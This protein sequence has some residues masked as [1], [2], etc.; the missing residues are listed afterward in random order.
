[1]LPLPLTL[2]L[3]PDQSN[4]SSSSNGLSLGAISRPATTTTLSTLNTYLFPCGADSAG[5]IGGGTFNGSA[6]CDLDSNFSH[7]VAGGSE[8]GSSTGHSP[9]PMAFNGAGA[10]ATGAG[11]AAGGALGLA[12]N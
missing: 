12:V 10:A 1:M 3:L 4:Q 5:T 11:G 2:Q 6:S 7:M 8:A 9:C